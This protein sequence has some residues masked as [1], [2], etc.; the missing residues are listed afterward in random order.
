MWQGLQAINY[1]KGNPGEVTITD[2]SLPDE[3]NLF[4]AAISLT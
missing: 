4:Y 2:P 1:Y 3:L